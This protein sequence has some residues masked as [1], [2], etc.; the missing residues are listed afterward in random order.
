MKKEQNN[1]KVSRK[2]GVLALIILIVLVVAAIGG[3][4]YFGIYQKELAL[5]NNPTAANAKENEEIVVKVGKLIKLPN[6]IPSVATVSDITKL[7][8][9]TLFKDAQNGDKVLIFNKAKRA[10]VYRPSENLIIEIGNVVV[11]PDATPSAGASSTVRVVLYNGTGTS[12]YARTIGNSLSS[13]FENMEIAGTENAS[14]SYD[15]TVVID[16][17]GNNSDFAKKLSSE[18]DGEVGSLPSG[19][20]RPA[21]A[22]ILVILGN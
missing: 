5:K 8:D 15:K 10:I 14:N 4:Y 18:L 1:K 11:A 3:F 13:K 9:Q 20:E 19:E 6:E 16:L 2:K 22:D 12:G 7:A 17:S 21:N